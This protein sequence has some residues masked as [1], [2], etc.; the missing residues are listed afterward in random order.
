MSILSDSLTKQ[1]ESFS[2]SHKLFL[3]LALSTSAL[4]LSNNIFSLII[5]KAF[6]D[7]FWMNS[8]KEY[9]QD[10]IYIDKLVDNT[11]K[12]QQKN[13]ASEINTVN[14]IK[15]DENSE[16]YLNDLKQRLLSD[17]S[18]YKSNL[19]FPIDVKYNMALL[20]SVTENELKKQGV[21]KDVINSLFVKYLPDLSLE[22]KLSKVNTSFAS[23]HIDKNISTDDYINNLSK[24]SNCQVNLAH[25]DNG[26]MISFHSL[27]D[28]SFTHLNISNDFEKISYKYNVSETKMHQEFILLHEF[29]HCLTETKSIENTLETRLFGSPS[30]QEQ[31]ALSKYLYSKI[32][33]RD[34]TRYNLLG[35]YQP[36]LVNRNFE[37]YVDTLA[38]IALINRYSN[39]ESN[40]SDE[41]LKALN[42]TLSDFYHHR[43]KS[44]LVSAENS[45]NGYEIFNY[46]TK[47]PVVKIISEMKTFEEMNIFALSVMEESNAWR[48]ENNSTLFFQETFISNSLGD[49][50]KMLAQIVDKDPKYLNKETLLSL[51]VGYGDNNNYDNELIKAIIDPLLNRWKDETKRIED[52]EL[53]KNNK[54]TFFHNNF[55]TLYTDISKQL[56]ENGLL[57]ADQ[58]FHEKTEVVFKYLEKNRETLIKKEPNINA[59][60]DI[61]KAKYKADFLYHQ[62]LTSTF[63]KSPRETIEPLMK[64]FGTYYISYENLVFGINQKRPMDRIT[65]NHSLVLLNNFETQV[66]AYKNNIKSYSLDTPSDTVILKVKDYINNVDDF[67]FDLPP[68]LFIDKRVDKKINNIHQDNIRYNQQVDNKSLVRKIKP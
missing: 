60:I 26:S 6:D 49:L 38:T 61:L 44:H 25:T 22:T 19:I 4:I 2:S 40:Y 48:L 62:L 14:F 15:S 64:K 68:Y 54:R 33:F 67:D 9:N 50:I 18:Y 12:N 52:L 37:K 66:S 57:H 21:F 46:L 3:S 28:F 10:D 41:T 58:F 27:K 56:H 32:I 11:I 59:F 24:V 53:S 20:P 16:A 5:D 31:L 45:H 43:L 17:I 63:S 8:V 39:S 47:Q 23:I 29:F 1:K 51:S 65:K 30:S 35:Y 7:S 36:E 34:P 55:E 42:T 13:L